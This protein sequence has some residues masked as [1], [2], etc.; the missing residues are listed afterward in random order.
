MKKIIALLLALMMTFSVATVAFATEAEAPA[1][2]TE[3]TA[4]VETPE[5]DKKI[6]DQLGEMLGEYEKLLDLP[7][8]VVGPALKIA[9]IALKFL[10]VYLKICDVFHLDP[11]D[12]AYAIFDY[13]SGVL[14]DNGIEIPGTGEEAPEE[15]PAEPG[16]TV[17]A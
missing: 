5:E 16:T 17:A 9:K 7:F 13:V 11:V 6:S 1:E 2:D 10:K 4:P 12:T 15:A 14:E 3:T 8:G